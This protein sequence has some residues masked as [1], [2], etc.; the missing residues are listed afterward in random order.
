[1]R[2]LR[3]FSIPWP[4]DTLRVV[5]PTAPKGRQPWGVEETTWH[6]L[7]AEGRGNAR[8]IYV[9]VC[10]CVC[11]CVRVCVCV[12]VC[13]CVRMGGWCVCVCVCAEWQNTLPPNLFPS[14]QGDHPFAVCD[15]P[16]KRP[17]QMRISRLITSTYL[18][19]LE[20]VM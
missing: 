7:G 11:V 10:V 8:V 20:L 15:G 3:G 16:T 9:C 19:H 5:L 14:Q 2:P 12:C 18:R 17:Q 4:S 13:A 1:M 6:Q